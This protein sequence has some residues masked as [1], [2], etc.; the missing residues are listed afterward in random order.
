MPQKFT[1]YLKWVR[2]PRDTGPGLNHILASLK[3]VLA[4]ND[5][6]ESGL[7]VLLARN[8]ADN[9][10]NTQMRLSFFSSSVIWN[11]H[12]TEVLPRVIVARF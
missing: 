4:L 7:E 6:L 12:E 3:N 11:L 8:L 10:V 2:I 9:T 5:D 1:V